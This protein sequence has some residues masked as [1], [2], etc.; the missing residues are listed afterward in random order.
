MPEQV[1]AASLDGVMGILS[2]DLALLYQRRNNK[3]ADL[4]FCAVHVGPLP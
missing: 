1:V 4:F 2:P 3:T